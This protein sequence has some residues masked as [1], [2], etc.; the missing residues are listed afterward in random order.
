[1]IRGIENSVIFRDDKD[2]VASREGLG[3]IL[4]ESSTPYLCSGTLVRKLIEKEFLPS[5]PS[6]MGRED[7][8]SKGQ[9]CYS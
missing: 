3:E 7:Y 5:V 6:P 8:N 4:L 1:M 2:R 9:K